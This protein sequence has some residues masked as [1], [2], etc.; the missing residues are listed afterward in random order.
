ML[1]EEKLLNGSPHPS[2]LPGAE[3]E[4]IEKVVENRIKSVKAD[5]E[6]QV[7]GLTTEREALTARLVEIEINQGVT[8][9]ATKRG[10]RPTA[11]PDAVAR[12]RKVFQLVN[13]VPTAYEPDGKSVRYGRD[14]VTPMTLDEWAEGR[15]RLYREW[16]VS[17]TKVSQNSLYTPAIPVTFVPTNKTIMRI[18]VFLST[19]AAAA[20]FTGCAGPESK[21]G[22]GL[23]NISE[24]ARMG[25]IR[26]SMEQ[27]A[28]WD[29]SEIVPTTGFLRGINRSFARTGIGIYEVVTFPFPPY[30]PVLAP[31]SALYPDPSISTV[32]NKSWGGLRLTDKPVFPVVYKPGVMTDSTF[33]PDSN[34]GFSSGDAFPMVPGSRFRT[35][36]P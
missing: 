18:A 31:N 24:F 14:G 3:R 33:E 22:R 11:I 13:G 34:L 23:N 28:I 10:L 27:T 21:F 7:A 2:P 5:L 29:G 16:I 17:P 9:A 35:L 20:L 8:L 32:A 36:K 4:K 6:K 19:V 15:G 30:G 12:A 25:E 26:R 1:E